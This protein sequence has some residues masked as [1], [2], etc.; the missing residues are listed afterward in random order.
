MSKQVWK[1]SWVHGACTFV[2]ICWLCFYFTKIAF[3]FFYVVPR[4]MNMFLWL[5][6]EKQQFILDV[7]LVLMVYLQITYSDFSLQVSATGSF[8]ECSFNRAETFFFRMMN[9]VSND[10]QNKFSHRNFKMW[11]IFFSF[12]KNKTLTLHVLLGK[13]Q[14]CFLLLIIT[15]D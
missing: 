3:H 10:D 6:T 14:P 8:C 9:I 12:Q 2:H 1:F 11:L 13:H 15:M 5:I 7:N 4:P